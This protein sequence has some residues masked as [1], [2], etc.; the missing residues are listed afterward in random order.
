[1]NLIPTN[2]EIQTLQQI[3]AMAIKTG[4]L[5]SSIKTPEQAIIIA[6]K[7]KEL[8]IPPFQAFSQI[9]IVQGKPTISAELM[10]ALVYKNVQSAEINFVQSDNTT[11]IIEARRNNA[12]KFSRFEFSINDAKN[13]GLLDKDNWRKYTAAMLRARGITAMARAIFSDAIAGVSYTPEELGADV[14]EDGEV[15]TVPPTQNVFIKNEIPALEEK[16]QDEINEENQVYQFKI[17]KMFVDGSKA[18]QSVAGQY[19]D[20]FDNDQLYNWANGLIE[21][22]KKNQKTIK[23]S[24]KQDL[25]AVNEYLNQVK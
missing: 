16:I 25:D 6:L 19:I 14:N 24:L 17:A 20:E 3:G 7:G 22:A 1:M 4:F 21:W 5:P 23:G 8:G 15:I 10:L 12:H 2:Q 18:P 13:A 11:C 9:S